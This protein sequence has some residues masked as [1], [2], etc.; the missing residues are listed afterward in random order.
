MGCLQG[1]TSGRWFPTV[2]NQAHTAPLSILEPSVAEDSRKPMKAD[3]IARARGQVKV[4]SLD[5]AKDSTKMD[6]CV[7]FFG[8]LQR[9]ELANALQLPFD[10]EWNV[11][12]ANATE[13]ENPVED[14]WLLVHWSPDQD[15]A[16]RLA[17]SSQYDVA[18]R[19][20]SGFP[21]EEVGNSKAVEIDLCRFDFRVIVNQFLVENVRE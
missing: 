10:G 19:I 5:G 18:A 4:A 15:N 21:Q 7:P 6:A 9:T 2:E 20:S 3:L 8:N 11:L 12:L 14:V 17:G 13:K 16:A 1:R